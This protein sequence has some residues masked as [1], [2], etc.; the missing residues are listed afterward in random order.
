MIYDGVI[1]KSNIFDR[2]TETERIVIGMKYRVI[3]TVIVIE[4]KSSKSSRVNKSRRVTI[5]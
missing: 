4:N 5:F 1:I 3:V 2:F